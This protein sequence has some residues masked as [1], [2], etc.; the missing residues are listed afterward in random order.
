MKPTE[1]LELLKRGVIEIISE[2]EL[3]DKLKKGKPLR[4]KAGFD[5]TT[6]DL[7]LGHTVL[8]QKL[9][10]FQDLGHQVIFLIGDYTAMVGDPTGRSETRP[11]LSN[12][13]IKKNIRTYE[14]QVF[15]ILDRK[16]TQTCFNSAWLSKMT[17]LDFIELVAKQ[18]VARMLE[19][20][21]FQNRF[22]K[23]DPISILEFIYPLLQAYDSVQLRADVELGGTDQK[24][25]LLMGRTIQKL[26]NQ[27]S[28]VVLTM[29][30]LVGTDGVQKM[31]KSY[32][33]S[34]GITETP[35]QVFGKLMSIS[36][37][38]MWSYYE[39]LSNKSLSEI[40]ALKES[41]AQGSTHPKQAKVTLAKEIVARFHS[42]ILAEKAAEEFERI[43][44][45]QGL[46]S[47]IEETRLPTS[48]EHPF[49]AQ[50]LSDLGMVSSRSEARRL[51]KQDAVSVND[52]KVTNEFHTL[53]PVGEYLLKVGKRRF[54]K[55][56]FSS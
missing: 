19:R 50:I 31:S 32:G 41:V 1:Q 18:T 6:P 48:K 29:P 5:P 16:R 55:L 8:L 12:G 14:E 49:L 45:A 27:D 36:D 15:K 51:I 26:Y 56:R 46:P 34:I 33:N 23:G 24:F 53:P 47:E 30:L 22:K 25:N 39:L 52:Q 44:S 28:Q 40:A 10:Q 7:H 43:F 20:D 2:P 17:T 13:E 3:F 38:L 37:T 21:D 9:K 4:I 11:R 35:Q 42:P 54:K